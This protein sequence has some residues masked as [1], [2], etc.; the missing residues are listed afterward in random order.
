MEE[1]N[2][3]LAM[4]TEETL[5]V[6]KA[7]AAMEK[8]TDPNEQAAQR[9]LFA[10]VIGRRQALGRVLKEVYGVEGDALQKTIDNLWDK[11]KHEQKKNGA[12]S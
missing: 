6:F 9:E 3:V 7:H 1:K 5:N 12:T 2:R 4:Y 10:E 11:F 8:A